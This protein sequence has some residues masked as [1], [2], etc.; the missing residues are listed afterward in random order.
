MDIHV[1]LGIKREEKIYTI[2][3][4]VLS[5]FYVGKMFEVQLFYYM[6]QF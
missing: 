5:Y 1:A 2:I 6:Q 3:S 4:V